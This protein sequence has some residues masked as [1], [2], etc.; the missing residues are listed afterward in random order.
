[1]KKIYFSIIC[2]KTNITKKLDKQ[3]KLCYKM[4]RT[5][6]GGLHEIRRCCRYTY[7]SST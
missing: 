2:S 5:Y 7:W 1:M 4:I 6:K 3:S